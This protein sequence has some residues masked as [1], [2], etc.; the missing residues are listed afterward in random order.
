LI[1]K[2]FYQQFSIIFIVFYIIVLAGS[3]IKCEE[4]NDWC[5]VHPFKFW[6]TA[7]YFNMALVVSY[8][9]IAVFE[10]ML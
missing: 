10:K 6:Q 2:K 5:N 9:R 1:T 3:I 4:K 8:V 7:A